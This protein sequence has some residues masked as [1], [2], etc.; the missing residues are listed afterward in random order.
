[1][2]AS[3]HKYIMLMKALSLKN[4]K[5]LLAIYLCYAMLAT[6]II[7]ELHVIDEVLFFGSNFKSFIYFSLLSQY[8]N[9]VIFLYC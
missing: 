4:L 1:M 8:G 2:S 3:I 6:L 7:D 9:S 5:I